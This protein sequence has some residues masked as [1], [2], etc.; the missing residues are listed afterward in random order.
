MVTI[1]M[2]ARQQKRHRCIVNLK[3]KKKSKRNKGGRQEERE[4]AKKILIDFK[5][6][7]FVC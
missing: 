7:V 1:T 3:K 5:P 6:N 2:Y 4:E